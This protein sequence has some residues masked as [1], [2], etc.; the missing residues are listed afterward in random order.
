MWGDGAGWSFRSGEYESVEGEGS[1][2]QVAKS[3]HYPCGSVRA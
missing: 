2:R 3:I 1:A